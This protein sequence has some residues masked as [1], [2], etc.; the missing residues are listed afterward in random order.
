MII[1][2]RGEEKRLHM[3]CCK[4]WQKEI[5]Y[6]ESLGLGGHFEINITAGIGRIPN[7]HATFIKKCNFFPFFCEI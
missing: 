2:G 5:P 7:K 6:M 3:Q 1:D 4:F